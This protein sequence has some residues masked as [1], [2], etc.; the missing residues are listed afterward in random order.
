MRG[1]IAVGF[2]IALFLFPAV[3]AGGD[4]TCYSI[5]VGVNTPSGIAGCT[6]D[7]PTVG[8]VSWYHGTV[9]AANWCVYPWKVCGAFSVTSQQT[10]KT[11]VVSPHSFCDCYWFTDRRLVDL[12]PSQIEA[13]GLPLSGGLYT[14]IVTPLDRDLNAGQ[15]PVSLPDAAYQSRPNRTSSSGFLVFAAALFGLWYAVWRAKE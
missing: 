1:L 7:G 8:V 2:V 11:I 9:A 13:L 4:E 14:V 5:E 12:I 3:V 10:G 15:G 6:I